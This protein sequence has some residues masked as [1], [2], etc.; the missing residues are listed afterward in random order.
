MGF[1]QEFWEA[2]K[3]DCGRLSASTTQ[4]LQKYKLTYYTSFFFFFNTKYKTMLPTKK[5]VV[6]DL[7]VKN[8]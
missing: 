2:R 7:G 3:M 8:Q 4:T 1:Q 5:G 6:M